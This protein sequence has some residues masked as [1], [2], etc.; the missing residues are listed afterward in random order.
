MEFSL[1]CTPVQTGKVFGLKSQVHVTSHLH[2]QIK[3]LVWSHAQEHVTSH[4]H[5][6]IKG[7]AWSHKHMWRRTYTKKWRVWFEV[8]NTCVCVCVAFYLLLFERDEYKLCMIIMIMKQELQQYVWT[9]WPWSRNCNNMYEHYDHEA[10]IATICMSNMTTNHAGIPKSEYFKGR[11]IYHNYANNM[12]NM[13]CAE[14]K[15]IVISAVA[16]VMASLL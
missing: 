8:T 7:L 12:W 5:K 16:A 13:C 15:N 9:L 14:A 10:G 2:K 6:Q 3:G 11:H 4:L 1:Q